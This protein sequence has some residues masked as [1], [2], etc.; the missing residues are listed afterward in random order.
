VSASAWQRVQERV[1]GQLGGEL[2]DLVVEAVDGS[3]GGAELGSKTL[4][5]RRLG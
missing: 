1:V 2:G 3:A 5:S 4:T